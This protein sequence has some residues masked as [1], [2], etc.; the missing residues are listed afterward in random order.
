MKKILAL[1]LPFLFGGCLGVP[2]GV[3]PVQGFE[4]DKYLGKWY[5]IARLDHSFERGLQAVTAEYAMR[6]DGGVSVTNRGYSGQQEKW[7]D[8]EGKAF[9]VG[10]PQVGH[11]K[12]SFF[13]PFYGSYA[14]F[15]LD[16]EYQYAFISGSS[17]KYLW[18]LSRTPEVSQELKDQFIE[19]AASLGFDT[20]ALI[21]VDHP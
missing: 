13:G 20:S 8:A 4:L 9:F 17:T 11:L 15:E 10:E 1:M 16:S 12:V 19:K 5:E 6:P 18:F 3:T 2:E 21:F 7:K 14:V